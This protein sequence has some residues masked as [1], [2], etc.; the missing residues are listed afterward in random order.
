MYLPTYGWTFGLFPVLVVMSKTVVNTFGKVF[1]DYM[2][3]FLLG[4]CLGMELVN[5]RADVYL[6]L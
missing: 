4:I 5:H 1:G 6:T 3:L 2:F